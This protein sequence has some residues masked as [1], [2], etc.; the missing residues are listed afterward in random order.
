[1]IFPEIRCQG[2]LRDGSKCKRLLFRGWPDRMIEIKCPRCDAVNLVE[3]K[4]KFIITIIKE[5]ESARG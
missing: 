4:K 5:K 1:M 3:V 2:T